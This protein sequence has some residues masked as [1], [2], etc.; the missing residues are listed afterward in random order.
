MLLDCEHNQTIERTDH[1]PPSTAT[2]KMAKTF[3]NL[4]PEMRIRIFHECIERRCVKMLRLNMRL[5]QE[6]SPEL[7][8]NFVFTMTLDPLAP[9]S[10]IALFGGGEH[11]LPVQSEHIQQPHCFVDKKI[12]FHRFKRIDI[13]LLPPDPEDPGQ[14]VRSWLMVTRLLNWLPP[15]WRLPFNPPESE[16][17][18]RPAI[19]NTGLKLPRIQ[20]EFLEVGARRWQNSSKHLGTTHMESWDEERNPGLNFGEDDLHLLL[21]TFRRIR[22]ARDMTIIFPKGVDDN[23]LNLQRSRLMEVA[24]LERCFGLHTDQGLDPSDHNYQSEEDFWHLAFDRI[25]DNLPGPAA[26]QLRLERFSNW[27]YYQECCNERRLLCRSYPTRFG[28][29][30]GVGDLVSPLRLYDLDNR[31]RERVVAF[32]TFNKFV[33]SGATPLARSEQWSSTF[34]LGIPP[35]ASPEYV[36]IR[37]MTRIPAFQPPCHERRTLQSPRLTF[38][39]PVC[40]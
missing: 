36:A 34:R 20:L 9:V 19:N 35:A 38:R 23:D 15:R 13:R 40:R 7:Y 17:M 11:F 29:F 1:D 3:A 8:E 4:P 6:L 2:D 26:T 5:Y 18:I 39:C 12:P 27:C 31:M 25:L 33:P 37:V 21:L 14:L 28:R 24:R 22:Y 16:C 32:H 10:S 30:G